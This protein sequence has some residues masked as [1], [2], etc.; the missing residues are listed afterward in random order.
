MHQ[1]HIISNSKK[2]QKEYEKAREVVQDIIIS[3]NKQLEGEAN[4]LALVAYKVE[5]IHSRVNNS[6]KVAEETNKK[7]CTLEKDIDSLKKDKESISLKLGE[8]DKKICDFVTSKET[9]SIK[10]S[11]IEEQ[12]K[13]LSTVPETKIEAVIPIKRKKL[14]RN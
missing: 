4:N 7:V 3:F 12:I 5:A 1:L 8:L 13:Q 2:L 11:N 14:W 9:L 10:L 6:L